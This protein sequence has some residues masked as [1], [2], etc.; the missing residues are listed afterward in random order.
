V[1]TPSPIRTTA[2]YRA[3]QAAGARF[4]D[5]AGWR[6]A[7]VYTSTD[8]ELSRAREGVAIS[9][10][11]ACGKLGFRGEAIESVAMKL[12]GRTAPPIGR[13]ARERVS[14]A[15]VL[16]C[17]LAADEMLLLTSAVEHAAVAAVLA[18]T[19]EAAGCLH[20]TDLTSAFAVVDLMGPALPTLLERLVTVD[21]TALPPLGVAQGELARVH[22]I[23][24]RLDEPTL[25]VLRVLVPRESGDFVWRTLA[26]AGS[27][28]GLAPVGA[29]AHARLLAGR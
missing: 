27:D 13:A 5:N 17:R 2:M 29:A 1:T 19:V 21:L 18:G 16:A 28:L 9:D 22:A 8:A 23:M 3:Q 15:P 26:G 6:V 25:P 14:E 24:V 10:A 7:D 11:S 12:T 20:V 4:A